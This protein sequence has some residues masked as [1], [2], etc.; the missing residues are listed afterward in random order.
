MQLCLLH[1]DDALQSQPDFIDH[2]E[3]NGVR[4]LEAT[5]L[6]RA[7]RLWGKE[8]A[9]KPLAALIFA[10]S[11]YWGK[12]P[13]L[14]FMGSGDF[15]HVSALLIERSL[16]KQK[17]PV[18]IIHFDNHPDWV[19]FSGGMHCGSWVNRAA[20]NP[21]V[22]KIITIGVSSKD[23][24]RPEW[25]GANLE[26]MREGKLELFPFHH[27]PS[28]VK[29]S[30]G[31]GPGFK[32]FGNHIHWNSIA[33]LGNGKFL[34]MLLSRITTRQVYLTID[35]DVLRSE[36][37]LTNWDQGAMKLPYL[38]ELITAIGKNHGIVGA[39]VTGDYSAPR[40]GGNL[41]T[42]GKKHA[43]IWLDQPR[44]PDLARAARVNSASNHALLA[45]LQEAMA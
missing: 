21:N 18:T 43:E 28:R 44:R 26:L 13:I 16:A 40:Y 30:Y 7:V 3:R 9:I 33:E 29:K 5:Q 25:K 10:Q 12:E 23:L 31:S 34:D 39:D 8:A 22:A 1:L 38:L 2:C 11:N 41:V 19:H 36:D 20:A 35:K 42:R 6:G 4:H 32:Q 24:T 37:A 27:A 15:H 17:E 14:C 45:V